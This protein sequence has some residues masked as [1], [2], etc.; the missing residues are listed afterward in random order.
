M[1]KPATQS[2]FVK[3]PTILTQ[4]VVDVGAALA[5]LDRVPPLKRDLAWSLMG[6]RELAGAS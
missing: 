2:G 3:L 1:S 6:W 4:L 5:V